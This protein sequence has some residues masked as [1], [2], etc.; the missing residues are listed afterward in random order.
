M[1]QDKL[2]L[3][4]FITY[5]NEYC[6]LTERFQSL[7]WAIILPAIFFSSQLFSSNPQFNFFVDLYHLYF[8][9][10]V[11]G[12]HLANNG[13]LTGIDFLTNNGASA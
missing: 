9:Q 1:L 4:A 5:S 3:R 12:Y 2:K 8:P 7:P 6:F 10:F 13:T 11:E